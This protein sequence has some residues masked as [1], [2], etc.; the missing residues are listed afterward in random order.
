MFN[1]TRYYSDV[2]IRIKETSI[3]SPLPGYN[4]INENSQTQAGGGVNDY[5]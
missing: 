4:F 3:R 2:E 1:T 5:I